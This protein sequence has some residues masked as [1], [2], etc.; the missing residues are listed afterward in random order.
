MSWLRW[1]AWELAFLA[2]FFTLGLGFLVV[3][4][5]FQAADENIHFLRAW[6][7]LEGKWLGQR[8][9]DKAGDELPLAIAQALTPDFERLQSRPQEKLTFEQ[10]REHWLASPATAGSEAMQTR[11]FVDF[12]GA[13]R[14]SPVAYA[15]Q[16]LG[17]A[18]ARTLDVSV[19]G[20]MYIGRLAN[21][22]VTLGCFGLALRLLG[23]RRDAA[24]VMSVFMLLPIAVFQASSLSVDAQ[25]LGMFA[26]VFGLY[27][28]MRR[29]YSWALF[30]AALV[31]SAVMALGKPVY[32]L[33]CL[34]FA[35]AVPPPWQQRSYALLAV[36]TVILGLTVLWSQ[37]SADLFVEPLVGNVNPRGQVM[38]ILDQPLRVFPLLRDTLLST[39]PRLA[40]EFVGTLGWLDTQ[41]PPALI[42]VSWL[43]LGVALVVSTGDGGTNKAGS[44]HILGAAAVLVLLLGAIVGALYVFWSP[45]GARL[46]EGLQGRYFL[47]LYWLGW[48]SIPHLAVD[49]GVVRRLRWVTLAVQVLLAAWAIH[50]TFYRYWAV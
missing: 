25:T 44:I 9:G 6:H 33:A 28:R 45:V 15:P 30:A 47:P 48:L 27:L 26:L 34:I 16:A 32:G 10:F 17:L 50:V 14:Y 3:T 23:E 37:L 42:R 41:L 8:F 46:V 19:L 2:A 13:V 11:T 21:L 1:S 35:L 12:H 18:V 49:E 4:P 7:V 43:L 24:W 29:G 36:L 20:A 31:L 39:G 5:P 38:H 22:L 40:I